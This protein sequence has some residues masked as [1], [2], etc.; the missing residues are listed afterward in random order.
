MSVAHGVVRN[1]LTSLEHKGHCVDMDKC[2]ISI[3]SFKES[4]EIYAYNM[5]CAY[6][7]GIP[8]YLKTTKNFNKSS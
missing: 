6:W 2:F 8:T 5:T 1:I 3:S 7:V 4:K